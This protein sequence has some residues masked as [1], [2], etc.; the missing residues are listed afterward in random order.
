M[1]GRTS[2]WASRSHDRDRSDPA[3]TH[4]DEALRLQPD[5]VSMLRQTAWILATS[6]DA[7]VRN[8]P[9]AVELATRRAAFRRPGAARVRRAGRRAGRNRRI[10]RR[11][12]TRPSTRRPLPWPVATTR[13][14]TP[15]SSGRV[16]TARAC[17]IA[18]RSPRSRLPS[19]HRLM[20]RSEC[21]GSILGSLS[22]VACTSN[23]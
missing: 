9:R 19:L 6:P 16:S 8:G 17:P 7:T 22:V 23:C 4:L 21:L 12:S 11:P 18:S 1:P 10:S 14:S 3:L 15:S 5:N 2:S 20:R 13:W